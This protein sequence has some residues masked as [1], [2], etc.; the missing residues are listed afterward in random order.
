MV[1]ALFGWG[2]YFIKGGNRR[3][4]KQK[5]SL[6]VLAGAQK[7]MYEHF[8]DVAVL[9]NDL[10]TTD[11][12]P[13]MFIKDMLDGN[14]NI[15]AADIGCGAGRYSL[16]FL[17]HLGIH[18]LA[19]I[20]VNESMLEQA[21]SIL[22]AA[23]LANFSTIESSA[24]QIQLAD[25][26]IDYI[27]T[28]NAIHH[29]DFVAFMQE[30]ARITRDGGSIIIYTRLRSQNAENIWGKHF[31]LFLVK[32]TR[33]YE[34]DELEQMIMPIPA[35][36]IQC[37]KRFRYQRTASLGH[38]VNLA[39]NSHYSTFSLYGK[40]EF[41]SALKGFQRNITRHFSDPEHMKWFDDYTML[42][43]NRS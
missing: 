5:G 24:E 39:R 6:T 28:F 25:N 21:S 7:D 18:H 17:Q 10:R 37:V 12:E 40:E 4:G 15:A 33:L 30:A 2:Y 41:A 32:E 36:N 13:V 14:G 11:L 3:L 23:G 27:F 19:C 8:S 35:L 16:Q 31:P 22:R 42:V 38:L 9:Y 20:D 43:V 29:F 1:G 34:M 26:S